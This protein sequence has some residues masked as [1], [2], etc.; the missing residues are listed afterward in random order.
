M[1]KQSLL[2]SLYEVIE[3]VAELHFFEVY[4]STFVEILNYVSLSPLNPLNLLDLGSCVIFLFKLR[5]SGST[6]TKHS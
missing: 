2:I 1:N 6:R 4:V 5:K 3:I